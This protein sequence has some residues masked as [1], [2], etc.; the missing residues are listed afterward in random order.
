MQRNPSSKGGQNQLFLLY[1]VTVILILTAWVS[2]VFFYEKFSLFQE[3][4][5]I[6]LTMVFGSFV[7]GAT[8]EGGGAVAFPV[9]T[10]VLGIP[11]SEARIFSLMIQSVGMTMAGLFIWVRKI[12]VLW[13]VVWTALGAGILGLVVGVFFVSVPN[14]LPKLVFTFITGIFGVFLAWNHW[15]LSHP[16]K[17]TL[18]LWGGSVHSSGNHQRNWIYI[19]T[20]GFLGGIVSSM[21]GVGIDMLIFILLTLRFGIDEKISTPT[22]VV[23]M[24]LLSVVGFS[25]YGFSGQIPSVVWEYWLSAVP[26]VIFGAPFGAWVCSKLL[27]DHLIWLLLILIAIEVISTIWLIPIQREYLWGGGILLIL[28]MGL[29]GWLI[30]LRNSN[31]IPEQPPV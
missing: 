13:N 1:P 21:V 12:P 28:T 8:S 11:S 26:V 14:P 17:K 20:A 4:W 15:M 25:V 16:G 27:K 9:F 3:N 23:L 24:G 2:V 10:K 31:P 19:I 29:F 5:P 30:R 18:P 22:T 6:T 7:A